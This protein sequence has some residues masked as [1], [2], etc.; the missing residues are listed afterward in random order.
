MKR[1]LRTKVWPLALAIGLGLGLAQVAGAQTQTGPSDP[2]AV[3]DAFHA[4]GDDMEAALAILADDVVIDLTPPPPGTPGIW[5]GKTEARAFFE[6]RN[7]NNIRRMRE[8]DA[9]VVS[10]VAG[11]YEVNGNVGVTSDLF[12]R[13]GVGVVGHTFR[14]EV[15][16]G[17]LK[18]YAGRI[19]VE[20]AKRVA[21]ARL[22][23]EQ[24]QGQPAGMPRTGGPLILPFILSIGIVMLAAGTAL[25]RRKA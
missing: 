19:Q 10:S 3:V 4:A 17:K 24:S 23:F 12:R 2:V 9:H 15:Q 25:R 6:W 16:D 1:L 7:A 14:A 13:W 8:G 21:A 5:K 20:E 18:S 11:Q 22:A